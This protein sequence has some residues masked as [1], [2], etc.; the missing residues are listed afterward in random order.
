MLKIYESSNRKK[1]SW[2]KK[3]LFILITMMLVIVTTACAVGTQSQSQ[4]LM[5]DDSV[6]RKPNDSK[7]MPLDGVITEEHGSVADYNGWWAFGGQSD[8]VPFDYLEIPTGNC[9]DRYGEIVDRASIDYSEQRALN[10]GALVVFIFKEIG[11]FAAYPYSVAD[12][13]DFMR[14]RYGDELELTGEFKK[15]SEPVFEE[16][17][18]TAGSRYYLDTEN[19]VELLFP[20]TFMSRG[21]SDEIGGMRF[22]SLEDIAVLRYWVLPAAEE[23]LAERYGVTEYLNYEN[24]VTIAWG[25]TMNQEEGEYAYAVYLWVLDPEKYFDFEN[26]DQYANV[27]ILCLTPEDAERW[28]VM[29]Q[30]G[31]VAM[32]S[33]NGLDIGYELNAEEALG[34]LS[35]VLADQMADGV[36]FVS[37]DEDSL[38]GQTVYIIA[39][40][41]H[42]T[43]KF[44]AERFYAVS[45]YGTVFH[46]DQLNDEYAIAIY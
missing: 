21:L 27:A 35:G 24:G 20:D 44:T 31:A 4:A 40:G 10:G 43:D 13:G 7:E 33:A 25:E 38:N 16:K 2:M 32:H 23:N 41:N 15:I 36:A 39:Y 37:Y 30:E 29:L 46:Y 12:S 28:Y 1:G 17:E 22:G 14:V 19:M 26:A 8:D 5:S 9:Y 42:S 18:I 3:V 34:I 45:I 11:D 6:S